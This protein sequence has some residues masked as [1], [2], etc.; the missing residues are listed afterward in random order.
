MLYVVRGKTK[1]KDSVLRV[2]AGS[3]AEAEQIGWKNGLFVTEVTVVEDDQ[4]TLSKLDRLAG[5]LRRGWLHK[6]RQPLKC[7]GQPVS[8]AQ[9]VVLAILGLTTWLVD[10]HTL[11]LV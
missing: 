8:T 5:L 10:L 2:R 7:F 1:E 4:P 6:P 9:A 11:I 3:A